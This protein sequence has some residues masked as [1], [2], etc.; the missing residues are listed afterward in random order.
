KARVLDLAAGR[1]RH[2]LLL[3]TSGFDVT[4]VDRDAEALASLSATAAHMGVTLTTEVRDLEAESEVDLGA[5]RF[6]LVLVFH[7]LHRPLFPAIVR[8]VAPGGLLFYETFLVGQ[9]QR[10]RPTNPAFLLE[11]G[12]LPARVAPLVV[13]RQREGDVDGALVAS[14]V[15]RRD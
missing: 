7:C 15:A 4:A 11:P 2:A 10:G 3:A 8:S 13:L 6:D 5:A 12:E 9:A 1:G 14:V